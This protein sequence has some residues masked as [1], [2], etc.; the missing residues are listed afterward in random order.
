MTTAFCNQ[1][2]ESFLTYFRSDRCIKQLLKSKDLV[3]VSGNK[4]MNRRSLDLI[5]D[6]DWTERS[7]CFLSFYKLKRS[8]KSGWLGGL[9]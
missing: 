9:K 7:F 6:L 5:H 4:Y 2:Y 1:Y 3:I 8:Y